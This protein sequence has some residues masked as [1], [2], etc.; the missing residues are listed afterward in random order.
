MYIQHFVIGKN[1]RRFCLPVVYVTYQYLGLNSPSSLG[2][3]IVGP[4]N[5]SLHPLL[6]HLDI[7]ALESTVVSCCW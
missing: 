3:A 7:I 1:Q 2:V 4:K 6:L 5:V